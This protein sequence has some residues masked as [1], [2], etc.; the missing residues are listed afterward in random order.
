MTTGIVSYGMITAEIRQEKD[1]WI[2]ES[3]GLEYGI[4]E[5]IQDAMEDFISSLWDLRESLLKRKRLSND[6]QRN[7]Q[8]LQFALCDCTAHT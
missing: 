8:Y 2:V 6:D 4:G 7:L 1:D 3:H 5:T